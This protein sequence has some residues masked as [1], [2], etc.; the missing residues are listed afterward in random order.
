MVIINGKIV[1]GTLV[2]SVISMTLILLITAL[3]FSF[4]IRINT[5][6][7][8]ELRMEAFLL[9]K[10]ILSDIQEKHNYYDD[11]LILDN[12]KLKQQIISLDKENGVFLVVLEFKD[13]KNRTVYRYNTISVDNPL[14]L[15]SE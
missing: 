13:Q 7:I 10:S 6:N 1:G 8:N 4:F 3:V 9:S 15:I 5:S 12:L 2:E 11:E 14:L